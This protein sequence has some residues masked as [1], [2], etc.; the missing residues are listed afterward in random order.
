MISLVCALVKYSIATA[1]LQR[2][3]SLCGCIYLFDVIDLQDVHTNMGLRVSQCHLI[4]CVVRMHQLGECSQGT[5]REWRGSR[6]ERR[7]YPSY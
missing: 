2:E 7:C 1:E 6:F 4:S 3:V 5:E